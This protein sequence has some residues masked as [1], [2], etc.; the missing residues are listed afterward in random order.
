MRDRN[1]AVR[2]AQMRHP[3]KELEWR[4]GRLVFKNGGKPVELPTHLLSNLDQ[5]LRRGQ[6]KLERIRT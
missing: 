6:R 3:G 1:F 4:D 2:W 5:P